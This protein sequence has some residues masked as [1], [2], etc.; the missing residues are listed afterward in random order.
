MANG[1]RLIAHQ[2]DAGPGGASLGQ[3]DA[4]GDDQRPGHHPAVRP[5]LE[6]MKNPWWPALSSRIRLVR[7]ASVP[8]TVST[9]VGSSRLNLGTNRVQGKVL[10]SLLVLVR[11]WQR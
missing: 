9:R 10:T 11:T 7:M 5:F 8:S 3:A 2:A 6:R 4:L 1:V